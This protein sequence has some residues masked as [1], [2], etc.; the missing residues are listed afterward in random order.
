MRKVLM[1]I[2]V[3]ATVVTVTSC[4]SEKPVFVTTEETTSE[5]EAIVYADEKPY[6]RPEHMTAERLDYED[7]SYC[8]FLYDENGFM[9]GNELYTADGVFDEY[10]LYT[11]DSDGKIKAESFKANGK[12]LFYSVYSIISER[13]YKVE[14]YSNDG[15][16]EYYETV[17]LEEDGSKTEN[18]YLPDDTYGGYI[19]YD[20][21]GNI[22]KQE[23]LE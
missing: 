1:I 3:A 7:G 2:A 12:L 16:P 23:M 13:E 5:T 17:V 19:T 18:Y 20:A 6:I 21:E 10:E 9:V 15:T 11:V 8:I 4:N 22:I 14:H